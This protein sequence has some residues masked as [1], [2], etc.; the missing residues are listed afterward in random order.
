MKLKTQNTLKTLIIFVFLIFLGFSYSSKAANNNDNNTDILWE[1]QTYT[2]D[3]YKGKALPVI[4]SGVKAT[5]I[6]PEFVSSALI[7]EWYLNFKKDINSSGTGKNYF[8]FQM[9]SYENQVVTVRIS[10]QNKN[11]IEEKSIILS[12][13]K[14][15]SKIIFYEESPSLGALYNKA[16]SD[17]ILLSN[18]AISI[19]AEPYFFSEAASLP[20]EWKIDNKEISIAK[21]KNILDLQ[22]P[23]KKTEDANISLKIQNFPQ[24]LQFAEKKL[25]IKF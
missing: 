13:N 24:V 18:S 1:A 12:P 6:N 19:K 2:P 23:D 22:R 8:V 16:L 21:N 11:V 17:E 14:A 20:Y 7:Y 4:Q 9:K 15:K 5:V 10:D 25:R 3:W